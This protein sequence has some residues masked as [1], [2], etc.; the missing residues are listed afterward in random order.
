MNLW[1]VRLCVQEKDEDLTLGEGNFRCERPCKIQKWLEVSAALEE[2]SVLCFEYGRGVE[3][4][5]R[6][7]HKHEGGLKTL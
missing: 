5:L 4:L 2:E 7:R 3:A 6:L 1:E